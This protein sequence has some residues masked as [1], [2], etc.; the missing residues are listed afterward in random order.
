MHGYRMPFVSTLWATLFL[1]LKNHSLPPDSQAQAS[2]RRVLGALGG[3]AAGEQP[4]NGGEVPEG[5]AL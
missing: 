5:V 2:A 3:A 4:P 1:N